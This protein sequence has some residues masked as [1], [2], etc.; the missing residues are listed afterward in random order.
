MMADLRT[1]LSRVDGAAWHQSET[2][3]GLLRWLPLWLVT[4]TGLWIGLDSKSRWVIGRMSGSIVVQKAPPLSPGWLAILEHDESTAIAE[5]S[6]GADKY[7]LPTGELLESLPVDDVIALALCSRSA[8]WTERA[9]RW[10]EKRPLRGDIRGMLPEIVASK[11]AGQRA[12]QIAKRLIR[13]DR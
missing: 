9:L 12:R 3:D 2:S 6:Y 11:A 1:A 5:L 8:H 13:Q 10:L 4:D 7:E